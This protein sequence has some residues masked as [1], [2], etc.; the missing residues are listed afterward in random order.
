MSQKSL[1][2]QK[3]AKI[4]AIRTIQIIDDTQMDADHVA[5]VLH[6]LLGRDVVIAHHKSMAV[7][8]DR[9]RRAMPDLI[10]LDD[11]LPP[12]DRAESSIR[13]L[14]R[15][16]Y[17][18]PIVVMSGSLTRS[19]KTELSCFAP[20]GVLSKDDINSFAIAEVLARLGPDRS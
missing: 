17:A 10:F 15:F 16:G 8:L 9:M 11:Y 18:G 4:P 19:R 20:L 7:A 5:A 3:L 2:M 12:L 6:L 14:H 1:L 13:S